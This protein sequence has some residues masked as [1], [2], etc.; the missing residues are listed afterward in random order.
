ME[1]YR[2][3]PKDIKLAN[4]FNFIFSNAFGLPIIFDNE[5]SAADLKANTWGIYSTNIY[6][7]AGNGTAIKITGTELS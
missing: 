1:R 4:I 3:L 6:I 2:P 7:K 5:P